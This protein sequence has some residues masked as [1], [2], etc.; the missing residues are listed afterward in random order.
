[1]KASGGHVVR[2]LSEHP[3]DG[4]LLCCASSQCGLYVHCI[5]ADLRP[6]NLEL[7]DVICDT[8]LRDY[9]LT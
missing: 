1:M 7:L 4:Y 5:D 6:T 8:R 9:L 2:L 3:Q